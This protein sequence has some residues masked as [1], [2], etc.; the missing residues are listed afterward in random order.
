MK[1]TDKQRIARIIDATLET[2][3][4]SPLA[5]CGLPVCYSKDLA[6]APYFCCSDVLPGA[7]GECTIEGV[8]GVIDQEFEKQWM[9]NE[10]RQPKLPGFGVVLNILNIPELQQRRRVTL[11]AELEARIE[12]FCVPLV[13][14]LA[15]MPH[16]ERELVS[17]LERDEL[18]GFPLKAFSGYAYRSKFAAFWEFVGRLRGS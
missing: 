5:L 6:V 8:I 12:G 1:Q 7:A 9:Q 15:R 11:G 17:A 14:R 18:C 16:D 13:D 4:W 10:G 2:R 3:G